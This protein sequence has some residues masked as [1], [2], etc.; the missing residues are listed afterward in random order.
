MSER[1][2]TVQIGNQTVWVTPKEKA[3]ILAAQRASVEAFNPALPPSARVALPDLPLAPPVSAPSTNLRGQFVIAAPGAPYGPRPGRADNVCFLAELDTIWKENVS[4]ASEILARY[5]GRGANH[6]VVNTVVAGGYHGQYPAHDWRGRTEQFADYLDWLRDRALTLS[7][8]LLPDVQP[9]YDS[10][11]R[12]FDWS[13]VARDL[14]PIYEHPRVQAAVPRVVYM[15]E[16]YQHSSE[17]VR[18]YDWMARTF[19]SARRYWHN[20]PGHLS[21]GLGS[22]EDRRLWDLAAAHGIHGLYMQAWPPSDRQNTPERSPLDQMRYD[23]WDMVRRFRG[24]DSPWGG[25][26]LTPD[27]QPLEVVWAEGAAF[28]IYNDG[29]PDTIGDEWA[30][31]ALAVDGVTDVLDGLLA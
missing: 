24:V 26:V 14:T 19:P 20:P 7:A 30:R 6:I 21:P 16:D 27:G 2:E 12:L 13:A 11:A 29:Y 1:T 8:W 28:S 25:P 4:A 18:G 31:G 10:R 22:E 17:M 23:L 3:E 15:W 5:L 9:Y